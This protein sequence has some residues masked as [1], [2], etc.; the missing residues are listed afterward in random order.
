MHRG[1]CNRDSAAGKE[2][3]VRNRFSAA[4][5]APQLS[6]AEVG[7]SHYLAFIK[8]RSF[9]FLLAR[10]YLN[11][12]RSMLSSF[13]L[14]SLIGVMLGVLVLVVVMAVYAGLERNVKSRLLGFTPHILLSQ[15]DTT[16]SDT[17]MGDWK[18]SAKRALKLPHV[19]AAT[20][21]VTYN[22]IVDAPTG[23]RPVLFRGVDGSDPQQ[24]SGIEKM[25]DLKKYPSSKA[26]LGIDDRVVISS[27]L[28]EQ[29]HVEVGD[30]LRLYS[31]KNF[32]EVMQAY[33]ATEKPPLR[34]AFAEVWDPQTAAL[35]AA[36][37]PKDGAFSIKIAPFKAVYDALDPLRGEDLRQPEM[38]LLDQL[39]LAMEAG[40]KNELLETYQFTAAGK[41]AIDKAIAELNTTDAEKMDGETLKGLKSIVLPKETIIA[42]V[43]QASQM[44]ITPD[45]FIPLP[46]AQNLAGLGDS[47]QGIALRLDDP[48][49]AEV[50]AAESRKSLGEGWT[51]LTWGEQ[52]QGFFALINQQRVMMYFALSF[53]VL[54]SA[55]SMMAVM[56][57]V[58]IQKRREIGV[59]KALGAA[60]GQIVRVFLY[61]GMLLGVL[62]A[63]LGV[64]FGR[65]VIHFRGPIQGIFRGLGFDPFAAGFTG[66]DVLPAY[67]NPLEQALIALMAFVLCSAAALVPA[68]FAARSDAAKSLRNL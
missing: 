34:T 25:L 59:M 4:A 52:Y 14:I 36:W 62:G 24:V 60:P 44:T 63:L 22:V 2:E 38:T 47:V 67:N 29:L 16:R 65:L 66:F 11:P 7:I 30:S 20:A 6:L 56:F 3:N 32:E 39:L 21:S 61:Q 19:E 68:F 1:F 9:S 28:A 15:N 35:T 33:K 13:T 40:E 23:Q 26:D 58:T 64:G 53:I 12:R 27:I 8:R 46:L 55:F 41:T 51:L 42:G 57:T 48:Y 31:T 10:R 49:L 5:V 17:Q 54:V 43:Y 18:E 50:V 37:Q 45:L